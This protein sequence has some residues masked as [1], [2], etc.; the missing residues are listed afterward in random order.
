MRK[1]FRSL[2]EAP[3]YL[4]MTLAFLLFLFNMMLFLVFGFGYVFEVILKQKI[5][6]VDGT[7]L[8]EH[9]VAPMLPTTTSLY[10]F[11]LENEEEFL[12][13]DGDVKPVI[14]QKGPY[15]FAEK[16][17]RANIEHHVHNGTMTYQTR[18]YWNFLPHLSQG[19]L[20]DNITTINFPVM[21]SLAQAAQMSWF[22]QW[23]LY[24]TIS[25][26]ES[27]PFV[28]RTAGE[29]LFDGYE[30]TLLSMADMM[31]KEGD[32]PMDKFAWFYKRNGT[33]FG[34]GVTN[35]HTGELD[36]NLV[37]QAHSFNGDTRTHFEGK[38]GQ[39]KGSADGF[40]PPY[41]MGKSGGSRREN[42]PQTVDLFTHQACRHMTYLK[43]E[44]PSPDHFGLPVHEYELDPKT[45]A[46]G[47]V[48]EPNSCFQ[49]NIPSGLQNNTFCGG[50]NVP[51]YLSFPHFYQ[52][53]EYYLHQFGEGSDLSPSRENHGSYIRLDPV[54]SAMSHFKFGL[55]LN[56]EVHQMPS[57]MAQIP[58]GL[59]FFPAM[60]FRSEVELPEE[61]AR[62][63]QGVNQ[64][65][66]LLCNIG[67]F[68]IAPITLLLVAVSYMIICSRRPSCCLKSSGDKSTDHSDFDKVSTED[69]ED[70]GTTRNTILEP[71]DKPYLVNGQMPTIIKDHYLTP[72]LL[73]SEKV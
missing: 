5:Q 14:K 22:M 28:T 10:L 45:F 17:E 62:R 9:W 71:C 57:G 42:M 20:D 55:Q 11:T 13:G 49:N 24:E 25:A 19:S 64:L 12:Q 72:P 15:V 6:L 46:N 67:M 36:F 29:L 69:S 1:A 18:R 44:T 50:E 38:C 59:R 33:T 2:R 27:T 48:H 7:P 52:A 56:I 40:F 60:W 39:I 34:D 41:T 70:S 32:R 68:S 8:Y 35:S 54:M 47:T 30:D 43:A 31:A 73:S 21:A 3:L 26:L 63:I 16:I 4:Q 58:E 51:I 61:N 66:D 23:G 53:D 65:P 37:N